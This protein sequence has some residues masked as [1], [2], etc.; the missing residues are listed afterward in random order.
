[1]YQ[2]RIVLAAKDILDKDFKIDTRGFRMTEVDTFLDIV[3][4]D[5]VEF[6][7]LIEE[8]ND[9]KKI[10]LLENSSL[11]AEIRSLRAGMEIAR[12]GEKEITNLD[13]IR[14]ISNLEKMIYR[15]ND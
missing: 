15:E 2:D 12:D 10:L 14:R 7:K 8:Y 13:L 4:R 11:K 1:M 3:I 6:E 9:E 5:Y